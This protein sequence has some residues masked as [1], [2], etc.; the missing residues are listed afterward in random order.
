[1]PNPPDV[2]M[3]DLSPE[4]IAEAKRISRDP[5]FR[6]MLYLTKHGIPYNL[7][8]ALT[9]EERIFIAVAVQRIKQ[10]AGPASKNSLGNE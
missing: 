6:S 1:M 7:A 9:P 3:S 4:Q 2:D 10:D 8:E 5:D